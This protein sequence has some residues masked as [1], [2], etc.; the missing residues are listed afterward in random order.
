MLVRMSGVAIRWLFEAVEPVAAGVNGRYNT[1]ISGI[2]R[3]D[4]RGKAPRSTTRCHLVRPA[5]AGFL[6]E[7]SVSRKL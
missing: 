7:L 5:I 3:R 2:A 4:M 1:M 6:S